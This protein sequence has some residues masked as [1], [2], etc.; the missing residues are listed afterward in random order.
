MPPVHVQ[1]TLGKN[2]RLGRVLPAL[3]ARDV[4]LHEASAAKGAV[5][6]LSPTQG[7]AKADDR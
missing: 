6:M 3:C 5:L 2:R 7:S 1:V 4:F